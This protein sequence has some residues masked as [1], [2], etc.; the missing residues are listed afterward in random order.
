MSDTRTNAGLDNIST[1][2]KMKTWEK[3]GDRVITLLSAGNLATTQAV[4]GILEELNH[5]YSQSLHENRTTLFTAETLFQIATLIG[6]IVKD[7][8]RNIAPGQQNA[9]A[10]SASF[11]LGGQIK[12]DVPRL[13]F[14]Y[15]EGNFIEATKDTPFFQIGEHKYG[16]PII[17]RAYNPAMSFEE[18]TKLLLVSFDST[19]RSN[20][21]VGLPF[22]LLIYKE[23]TYVKGIQK[24]IEK[25]DPYYTNISDLWSD[26]LKKAFLQLPPFYF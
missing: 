7:T 23:D 10:F 19:L 17:V 22:D 3:Q 24:R 11:I 4:V 13:F 5:T 14:I 25:N 1:F 12:G 8:I 26:A 15:P 20:L 6:Q 21:S 16:K 2:C 9:D 18:A